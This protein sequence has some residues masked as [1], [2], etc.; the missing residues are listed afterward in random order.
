[1]AKCVDP[2]ADVVCTEGLVCK[3]VDQQGVCTADIY[4]SGEIVNP[5][6][7]VECIAALPVCIVE[8]GVAKCVDPCADV[9]CSEDLVCKIVDQQGVCTAEI[10]NPC[11]GVVCIAALP[12]CIVEA[13][14][15]KCVDPCADVVCSEELV[16]KIVD[17]Q[18]VCIAEFSKSGEIQPTAAPVIAT[19]A[20]PVIAT[21]AAPYKCF[22][23]CDWGNAY[24][25]VKEHGL[26]SFAAL[27]EH[28]CVV[29][30]QKLYT[31]TDDTLYPG[32]EE[33][34]QCHC[35]EPNV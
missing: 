32:C 28:L 5:C 21:T 8:A 7:A 1:V 11:D 26:G 22:S 12:V 15:A 10:V 3:I 4:K 20:A 14:V 23:G 31:G 19:T 13:G 27:E 18:A 24:E 25:V 6:A 2:C 30:N 17:Q 9:V 34:T 35:C 33:C 16:C 29:N